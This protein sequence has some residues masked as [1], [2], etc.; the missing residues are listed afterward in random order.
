MAKMRMALEEKDLK[1]E[2]F[3]EQSEFE[4]VIKNFTA[5]LK[6]MVLIIFMNIH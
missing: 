5:K 3:L 1:Q 4:G 2:G 6:S